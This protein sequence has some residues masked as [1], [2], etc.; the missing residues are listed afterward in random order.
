MYRRNEWTLVDS[1]KLVYSYQKETGNYT[2]NK[3]IID[4]QAFVLDNQILEFRAISPEI[5]INNIW[6][7]YLE[8]EK[9]NEKYFIDNG[10]RY[11]LIVRKV[12]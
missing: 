10:I 8:F 12:Y 5:D 11:S 6:S 4:P 1:A 2:L 3:L 7:T 9:Q